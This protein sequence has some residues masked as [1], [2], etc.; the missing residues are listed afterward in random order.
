MIPVLVVD[1]DLCVDTFLCESRPEVVLDEARHLFGR[2][3]HAL[4]LLRVAERLVQ[5]RH[6]PDRYAR[7]LVLLDV[8]A[9]EVGPRIVI[10]GQE[11]SSVPV[12]V[13]LHPGGRRPGGG[14]YPEIRP[15]HGRGIQY[16]RDEVFPVLLYAEI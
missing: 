16:Q 4:P 9:E 10:L 11:R 7:P 12:V 3:Y 6:R 5:C 13:V 15:F 14:D 1:Q 8:P 2:E